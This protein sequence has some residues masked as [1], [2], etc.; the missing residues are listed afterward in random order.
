MIVIRNV[1]KQLI[2]KE[3]NKDNND[4]FI[5]YRVEQR[6]WYILLEIDDDYDDQNL[7]IPAART[8]SGA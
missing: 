2:P 8:R 6:A 1:H 4:L 5:V 3:S 7:S